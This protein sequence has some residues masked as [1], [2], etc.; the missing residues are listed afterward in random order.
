MNDT[1][2]AG[3]SG[4]DNLARGETLSFLASVSECSEP[5]NTRHP[6]R[7][8]RVPQADCDLLAAE[9][10]IGKPQPQSLLGSKTLESKFRLLGLHEVSRGS[11]SSRISGRGKGDSGASMTSSSCLDAS[12]DSESAVA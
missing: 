6:V 1:L 3:Q 11:K 8:L 12:T 5:C 7:L 2:Q 4:P 10:S 9:T